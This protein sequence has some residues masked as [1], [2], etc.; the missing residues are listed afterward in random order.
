MQLGNCQKHSQK[1]SEAINTF[2]QA[3]NLAEKGYGNL[4]ETLNQ[5]AEIYENTEQWN[6]ALDCYEKLS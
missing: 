1:Y 3:L 6:M 2:K 5:L 4:S